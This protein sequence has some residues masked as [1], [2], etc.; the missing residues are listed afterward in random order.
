ML[1]MATGVGKTHPKTTTLHP[2]LPTSN[3]S[4]I[5]LKPKIQ[6]GNYQ[7]VPE[8]LPP[9]P[10]PLNEMYQ[11]LLSIGHIAPEPLASVQ[12]PYPNWYK[13]KL[14]CEY[15]AGIVGH[16]IHTCN[17]FKRKLLQLIKARWI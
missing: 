13:P 1:K 10:L 12:P 17:A 3:P 5:T 8:Q 16:N 9:L 6:I 15:H 4:P 11:K 7:R 2:R 14:N